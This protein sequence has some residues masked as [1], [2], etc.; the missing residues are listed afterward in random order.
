MPGVPSVHRRGGRGLG[1]DPQPRQRLSHRPRRRRRRGAS[2]ASRACP[3]RTRRSRT[4][5]ASS[6]TAPASILGADRPRHRPLQA[7]HPQRR[8]GSGRGGGAACGRRAGCLLRPQRRHCRP[9][10]DTR[11][12]G[13]ARP[14]WQ[15]HREGAADAEVKL[16]DS[17][18][19]CFTPKAV[20]QPLVPAARKRTSRQD[21]VSTIVDGKLIVEPTLSPF[22]IAF[23]V[24]EHSHPVLAPV[25]QRPSCPTGSRGHP[26]TATRSLPPSSAAAIRKPGP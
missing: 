23:S 16:R 11:G 18:I 14:V 21:G 25:A 20:L 7:A 19:G 13:P 1:S 4:A 3:N 9:R 26:G 10:R 22:G 24:R 12:G 8:Q 5:R 2:P 17:W 15:R 6:R